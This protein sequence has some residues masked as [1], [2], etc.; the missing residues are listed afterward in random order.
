MAVSEKAKQE[1]SVLTNKELLETCFAAH[2]F[3]LLQCFRNY[4][5]LAFYQRQQLYNRRIFA[6]PFAFGRGNPLII[7]KYHF[8]A[9]TKPNILVSQ[10]G[11][12]AY[13]LVGLRSMAARPDDMWTFLDGVPLS[14]VQHYQ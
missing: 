5:R 9:C 13:L 2:N 14:V 11:F 6:V 4:L 1:I 8:T 3:K 10:P 7:N 12:Q